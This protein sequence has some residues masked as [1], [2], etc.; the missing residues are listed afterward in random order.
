MVDDFTLFVPFLIVS[1]ALIVVPGPNILVVVST[2][3]T[4]GKLRGLQTV[5]GTTCAMAFQLVIAVFTTAWIIDVLANGFIFIKWAGVVYLV[6]LGLQ[7]I[8][9]VFCKLDNPILLTASGSFFK[10]FFVS[11][12]NPKTI[13]FFSAFLPQFVSPS[14]NY[15]QQISILSVTFLLLAALIDSCY[16]ILCSKL[17]SIINQRNRAKFQHGISGVLYLGAG[18]WLATIRRS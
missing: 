11:L 3:I 13:L 5:A 17:K 16:A 4:H 6:Y 9:R 8:K 15:L 18:A 1:A 14:G 2:S 12:T 7:H 10:G